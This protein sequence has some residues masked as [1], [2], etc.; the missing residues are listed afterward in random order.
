M[1]RP[2]K[3]GGRERPERIARPESLNHHA[4]SARETCSLCGSRDVRQRFL[5]QEVPYYEC[6]VCDFVFARPTTN[7]NLE[8]RL[9]DYEIAYLGYLRESPQDRAN[10]RALVDWMARFACLEN[11]RVLDVGSGSGK[12]V[13]YLKERSIEACGLE[14][15]RAL[16]DHFLAGDEA[17]FHE[18][19]EEFASRSAPGPFRVVTAF[20]VIE[21]VADPVGFLDGVSR[22]LAPGGFLF[23]STP[24]TA[25]LVARGAGRRW[26][27]YNRYHLSYFSRTSI[28]AVSERFDL[29]VRE[30]S[31]RGR[32]HSIGHILEYLA[33]FVVGEGRIPIP[34]RL[35]SVVVP[36]NLRD[37]MYLCL[38]KERG[39]GPSE[40]DAGGTG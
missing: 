34:D 17:F 9:E 31:W 27:Y 6:A 23:L 22:L 3:N 14:P 24:D 10:F 39:A 18:T 28:R 16:F 7:A 19:V 4:L 40:S 8:N 32:Q 13:R 20:D 33:D 5:K 35:Q 25:S 2:G 1:S 12:F 36:L 11:T 15:S 30:C 38:Q 26:H 37:T 21:H 29:R